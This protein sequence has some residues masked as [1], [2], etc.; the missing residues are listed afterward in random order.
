MKASIVRLL[1]R[2][3]NSQWLN[4]SPC[5]YG[6]IGNVDAFSY[7]SLA[8]EEKQKP[9]ITVK[10]VLHQADLFRSCPIGR[11]VQVLENEEWRDANVWDLHELKNMGNR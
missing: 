8:S 4:P 3:L 7:S 9:G 1:L 11:G 5:Q 6:F 2:V 10:E